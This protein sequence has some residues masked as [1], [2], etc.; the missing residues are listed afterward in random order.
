MYKYH[1]KFRKWINQYSNLTRRKGD[2]VDVRFRQA[3]KRQWENWAV[4]PVVEY[5]AI[6]RAWVQTQYRKEK[7]KVTRY[8]KAVTEYINPRFEY[9]SSA[10]DLGTLINFLKFILY[11]TLVIQ[12][13]PSYRLCNRS[14]GKSIQIMITAKYTY[15]SLASFQEKI[16]VLLFRTEIF[17]QKLVC[18]SL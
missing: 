9:K 3:F 2:G 11:L 8:F 1:K 18:K 15:A 13:S 6:A 17:P 7:Q 4:T 5:W 16:N 14:K 12:V 10:W